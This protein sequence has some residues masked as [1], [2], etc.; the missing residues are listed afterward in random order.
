M[1]RRSSG[2]GVQSGR[3]DRDHGERRVEHAGRG[4]G[5]VGVG[6]LQRGDGDEA[7][8]DARVERVARVPAVAA[9][10]PLPV[11]VG[12]HAGLLAQADHARRQAEAEAARDPRKQ[13][14]IAAVEREPDLVEDGVAGFGQRLRERHRAA[15]DRLPVAQRLLADGAPERRA[16]D[17][18]VDREAAL[19]QRRRQRDRLE[20][21]T[22]RVDL[23]Q[24]AVHERLPLVAEIAVPPLPA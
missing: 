23:L 19:L 13:R 2:S 6:H 21:R 15:V 14:R 22:R 10:G 20:G 11:R 1:R 3:L 4:D 7:L 9:V 12:V 17:A 8:P 16:G 24:R 5:G 18:V